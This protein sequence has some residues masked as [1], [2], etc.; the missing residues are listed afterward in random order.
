MT[1]ERNQDLGNRLQSH[2]K[3]NSCGEVFEAETDRQE[4]EANC[5]YRDLSGHFEAQFK[6]LF[7]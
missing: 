2:G 6:L 5:S 4:H 3:C 1:K 7:T